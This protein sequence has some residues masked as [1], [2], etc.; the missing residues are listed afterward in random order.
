M[1]LINETLNFY[2]LNFAGIST[3]VQLV[4]VSVAE[5]L[6]RLPGLGLGLEDLCLNLAV[7]S[8]FIAKWFV[9]SWHELHAPTAV[10]FD[11]ISY[12]HHVYYTYMY[13]VFLAISV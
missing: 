4:L 6:V 2:W 11:P 7:G 9:A 5:W 13:I 12:V 10:P 3:F 8:E 1:L